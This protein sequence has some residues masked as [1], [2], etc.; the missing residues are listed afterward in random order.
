MA[1]NTRYP[2][3]DAGL[4]MRPKAK[5]L[6]ADGPLNG[7]HPIHLLRIADPDKPVPFEYIRNPESY[8]D[9]APHI[10]V[11]AAPNSVGDQAREKLR[12]AGI[13]QEFAVNAVALMTSSYMSPQNEAPQTHVRGTLHCS[14]THVR[15][16][17][18]M[19]RTAGLALPKPL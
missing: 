14:G 12:Q 13:L 9:Y 8:P 2:S 19:L 3:L 15:R 6:H 5:N 18:V 4:V 16:P 17:S 10:Q 11:A 1:L 7:V